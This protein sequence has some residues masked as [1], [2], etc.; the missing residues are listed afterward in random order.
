MIYQEGLPNKVAEYLLQVK[1][2]MLQPQNPF[3]W[4]SGWRSPIYCDNRV[5]L[6]SHEAR[7]YI[8][9]QMSAMVKAKYPTVELIAGTATAGIPWGALVADELALPFAYVRSKPKEHGTGKQIEGR[10]EVGQKVVVIEDLISTGGS[11]LKAIPPL[12]EEGCR[13]LGVAAI[14]SYGFP[15]AE[16]N[17]S[18]AGWQH[19]VLSN[20]EEMLPTALAQGYIKEE[21]VELLQEWRKNPAAWG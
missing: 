21:E 15:Q 19:Y 11:S 6:S 7:T 1:A 16:A 12:V 10:V 18:D 13:V 2:I 17:F 14:F 9:Q 5:S 4:A 20:Y 8:K 3:T